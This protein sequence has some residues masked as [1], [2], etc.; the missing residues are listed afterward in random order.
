MPIP[1]SMSFALGFAGGLWV[2]AARTTTEHAARALGRRFHL[3]AA[4]PFLNALVLLALV[5]VGLVALH[6]VATRTATL[7]G[8]NALPKRASTWHEWR[9]G[10]AL[11][12]AMAVAAVLPVMLSG[13][14][15]PNFWLQA[16]G[17]VLTVLSLTTLLV[18][19]L[20]IEVVFRG[21]I[22]MRMVR[23]LGPTVA[24]LLMSCVYAG[25]WA[26]HPAATKLSVLLAFLFGILYS[27][28]Y[29]RTH[30]IW[31]GWGLHFA[32]AASVGV[33]F[34]LPVGGIDAYAAMVDSGTVGSAWLSG[35]LYGPEGGLPALLVVA[36][37]FVALYQVTRELAWEH[38][39][40]PIVAAGYAMDIAPPAAHVAMEKAA[41]PAALV[42]ILASTPSAASTS[43]AMEQHLR[44]TR[45]P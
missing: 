2:L 38:T 1:R 5:A 17:L 27:L 6:W 33:L 25:V 7:R 11:G 21:Y 44:E 35:G 15:A 32:W 26:F 29:L 13:N 4:E 24:T 41:A 37:G 39:H 40:E 22:F 23:A 28:A 16:H 43:P 30:A 14:L 31:L 36:A 3:G 19:T 42:Q 45:E 10:A 9:M 12:W 34:G 20:A 18:L 8:V